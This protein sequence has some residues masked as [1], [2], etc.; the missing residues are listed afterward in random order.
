MFQ[1]IGLQ[2]SFERPWLM[3]NFGPRK[4]RD[5][6]S[7]VKE[8]PKGLK[9]GVW[10]KVFRTIDLDSTHNI[11]MGSSVT[12]L[13][14]VE[15]TKMYCL[16]TGTVSHHVLSGNNF[17]KCLPRFL[18]TSWRLHFPNCV[19]SWN[20]ARSSRR[21]VCVLLR[22]KVPAVK[23]STNTFHVQCLGR[24]G[25]VRTGFMEVFHHR[26][27]QHSFSPKGGGGG[28]RGREAVSIW[29]QEIWNRNIA[30]NNNKQEE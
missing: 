14:K 13:W 11:R 24:L 3:T 15:H 25:T 6:L 10:V 28:G 9:E 29:I 22:M 27:F 2:R 19:Q 23:L 30:D 4:S 17:K 7:C 26:F 16:E 1:E 12:K 21:V 5:P 18:T 8:S 20:L